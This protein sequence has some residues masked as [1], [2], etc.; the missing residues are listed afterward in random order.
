LFGVALALTPATAQTVSRT[1]TVVFELTKPI[2][3]PLN[4][5]WYFPPRDPGKA[6]APR[7]EDGAHQVMWE[8]LF[9]LDYS[10]GKLEPWLALS[11]TPNATQ[12]VWTLK[13]RKGV[14]WS[15]STPATNTKPANI[16]AFTADDVIFTVQ[17][18]LDT[19]INVTALEAV[20]LRRQVDSVTKP[21]PPDPQNL[22]VVFKLRKPN[23]RFALENFGGTLFG[24]FLIMP[25]HIWGDILDKNKVP[26]PSKF[27]PKPV[28]TGPYVFKG[29]TA[30]Q[31]TWA[32]NEN[33]WGVK[34]APQFKTLPKPSQVVWQYIDSLTTSKAMLISDDLDA[35]REYA[36]ADFTDAKSKNASITG[37]DTAS[38][39][40]WN[41]PCT[42][43]LEINL[44]YLRAPGGIL[45]PWSNPGLRK[46]LSLLVDRA[47]LA[48]NAYGGTTAPSTTMFTQ[49]G[50]MKPFIDA[51][52]AAGYSLAPTADLAAAQALLGAVGY[53][54]DADGLYKMG[55]APLTATINVSADVA[56]DL[57]GA[58]ELAKQL[59]AAGIQTKVVSL[60]SE[61]FWGRVVPTGDYEM[62][63]GWLSCG[64]VAEPYTSMS[65]YTA[66]KSVPLGARSP[67]FSNTG[68]W[69]TQAAK[70]YTAVVQHIGSL[71][72]G[73]PTIPGL[74]AAAYKSLA[75]EMPF[76]P[77]VQSPK[78]IPFDTRYW[79]GWPTAGGDTVPMHSWGAT[80]RLI[81][82]LQAAH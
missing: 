55:A 81:H 80:Q 9:L 7:R 29:N 65:R 57:A 37:W 30:T 20:M 38:S 54:K 67:G 68:R 40:A 75:D 47:S 6:D 71:P 50:G 33:W 23:P 62:V 77:L 35:A 82:E 24:S 13:L 56:N 22:T 69:D 3:N 15:D 74:V 78:I 79:K 70:D 59:N 64:S 36:L 45:T 60:P 16:K 46:A 66:D 61:E 10:T 5:N 8:P 44:K 43:Q 41:D 17:I 14:E 34:G 27:S 18:A 52:T 39:L 26:D 4:F 51:V 42:R 49:Y 63:Y 48:N 73:E 76:I 19:R 53:S 28:G 32:L 2:E 25:K 58:N 21:T 72:L 11:L 1:D 31:M 12:D